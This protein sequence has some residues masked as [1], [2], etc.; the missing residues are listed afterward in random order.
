MQ[1]VVPCLGRSL[2]LG[3]LP[4]ANDAEDLVRVEVKLGL[5]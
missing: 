4:G 3:L 2:L 5:E 1:V